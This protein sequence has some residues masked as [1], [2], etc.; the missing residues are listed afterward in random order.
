M[1]FSTARLVRTRS[2]AMAWLSWPRATK[3]RISSSR[4]VST[5]RR[6]LRPAPRGHELLHDLRVDDGASL[7]DGLDGGDQ[8]AAVLDALLEQIGASV[9]A[10]LEQREPIARLRVLT[11]HDH[12]HAGVALAKLGGHLKSLVCAGRRH[13]DVGHDHVRTLLAYRAHER[14]AVVAL[15]DQ[16]YSL[17]LRQD[18]RHG[19]AD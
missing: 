10:R 18:V 2:S 11:Q 12:A 14:V 17:G 4:G 15:G 9:G 1:C 19:L 6:A 3:D 13:A 16:L 8:L 5:Q 7:R